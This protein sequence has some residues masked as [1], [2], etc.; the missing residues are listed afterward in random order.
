MST[1]DQT[2]PRRIAQTNVL[3]HSLAL[4][5]LGQMGLLIQGPAARLVIDPYLSDSIR[6]QNGDEFI[7]EFLPPVAPSALSDLDYYLITH[8]H[9]DHLDPKTVVPVA[10][11]SPACTFVTNGWCKE[12]LLALGIEEERVITPAALEPASLPGVD[13]RLTVV[14]AAHYEV[15]YDNERG[16]RYTGFLLEWNGVTVYHSGDTIIYPGYIDTLRNLPTPDIA[17]VALNGRD[18][19]RD[20]RN[21]VGNLLPIEAARLAKTLKWG[22]LLP[23][24][25]D[26]LPTN[27]IPNHHIVEAL[28]QV[29][30]RQKFKF[31]QPGELLYYV[32]S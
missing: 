1:N 26:L 13:L 12:K 11:A 23:G 7:R 19:F 16:H 14:P 4:W 2:L 9:A 29:D 21:L 20:R 17:M 27:S 22:L 28:M 24:H 30:P 3:P 5:G 18:A 25:N 31:L 6:E 10:K 32:K 8:E 15:E